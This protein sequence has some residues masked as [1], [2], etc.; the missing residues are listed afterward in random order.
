MSK[1]CI[2]PFNYFNLTNFL[3][4]ENSIFWAFEFLTK[5]QCKQTFTI[6][7]TLI[8]FFT[9]FL[10]RIW[11]RHL[12]KTRSLFTFWLSI[13]DLPSI[14]RIILTKRQFLRYRF[15]TSFWN[16][17]IVTDDPQEN[18]PGKISDF[19]NWMRK[20]IG[21]VKCKQ[22]IDYRFQWFLIFIKGK[23]IF[24]FGPKNR[25]ASVYVNKQL[26]LLSQT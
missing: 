23:V 19:I 11:W 1:Q 8:S 3:I 4:F 25:S 10:S 21:I 20:I 17:N 13:S 15:K 9:K 16:P 22:I 7:V 5:L 26:T 24:S 18:F 2:S 14:W 12:D 6:F